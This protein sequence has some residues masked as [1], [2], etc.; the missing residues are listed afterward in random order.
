MN[1]CS[2]IG[3][4]NCKF[5]APYSNVNVSSGTHYIHEVVECDHQIGHKKDHTDRMLIND[6]QHYIRVAA[7]YSNFY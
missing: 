2:I 1:Q 6:L 4:Y 3:I 5:P 7:E